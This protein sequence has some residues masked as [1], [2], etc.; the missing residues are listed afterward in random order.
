MTARAEVRN[1]GETPP[2]ATRVTYSGGGDWQFR[3][4]RRWVSVRPRGQL[5]TD[6]GETIVQWAVAGL[7]ISYLPAFLVQDQLKAGSLVELLADYLSP[8]YGIY[9]LRP[10]GPRTSAKVALVL[11]AL[12]E[13]MKQAA[14]FAS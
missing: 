8:D 11:E 14:Y 3:Q 7:G 13:R 12:A 5:R 4:G 10:P 2:T 9:T 6:S 1:S